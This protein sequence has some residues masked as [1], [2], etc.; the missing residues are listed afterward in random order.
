MCMNDIKNKCKVYPSNKNV[1]NSLNLALYNKILK[2]IILQLYITT[3]DSVCKK[4]LVIIINTV[5]LAALLIKTLPI[6]LTSK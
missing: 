4:V 5:V 3:Y 1:L 6:L 2:K